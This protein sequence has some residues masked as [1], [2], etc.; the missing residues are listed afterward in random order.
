[1]IN[2][3]KGKKDKYMEFID[4]ASAKFSELNGLL[5]DQKDVVR[6]LEANAKALADA[7]KQ[8]ND[9]LAIQL[10][11]QKQAIENKIEVNKIEVQE[12]AINQSV[13][14]PAPVAEEV[15]PMVKARRTVWDWEV[16]DIR[17]TAKKM[18]DWT[19]IE[20][21]TDKIDEFLKAKKAEGIDSEEF[22][23][24]GIRFFL[25]KTF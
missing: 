24:A 13:N 18:P 10:M 22:T 23:V 7:E 17:E 2:L 4:D 14:R 8:K 19:S 15:I 21:K 6:Q 25:R 9:E 5:K 1:M 3:E 20:P 11:E 12:V 16:K